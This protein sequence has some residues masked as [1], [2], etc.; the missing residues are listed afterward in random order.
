MGRYLPLDL[1]A[2]ANAGPEAGK[3]ERWTPNGPPVRFHSAERSASL[4]G[5]P[6]GR[7]RFWGVPFLLADPKENGGAAWIV[8]SADPAWA[9]P[10]SVTVSLPTPTIAGSLVFAHCADVDAPES[11]VGDLLATYTLVL[12][13]GSRPSWPIRRGF[14][15]VARRPGV[16]LG[17]AYASVSH[18]EPR[19]VRAPG[20]AAH[21]LGGAISS[22]DPQS[23]WLWGVDNPRPEAPIVAIELAAAHHDVIVVAAITLV[24]QGSNPLRRSGRT[25]IRVDLP[26]VDEEGPA[27]AA[28]DEEFTPPPEL[29][30]VAGSVSLTVD[31]GQIVRA[32]PAHETTPDAW[33]DA[34]VKGWGRPIDRGEPSAIHAE[35]YAADSAELTVRRG[36]SAW[37]VPWRDV[38]GGEA[39]STDGRV[40][41]RVMDA[42]R[43]RV[44]V[45]VVDA[46]TGQE[47]ATRV[48]FQGPSGEYLPPLGHSPEVNVNWC[49]DI[50]G[51]LRL[52]ATN[53]AYVPGRFEAELPV[54]SVYA[55]AVHGF[56]YTPVREVLTIAPGQSDLRLPIRRWVD[57]RRRGYYSGD[58][59]VHFLDPSTATLEAAAEDLNVTELLAIQQG[60]LHE[61]TVHGIGRVAPGS[62]HEHVIR[63]DSE[64][65]HHMLGHIFLLGLTEPVLPLSSGGT[66]E[67]ELGG[68]D[69]V[70]MADWC[71]RCRAQGGLVVTQFTPTPHAE[72]VADIILGKI[73]ATEVRWFDFFPAGQPGG[74]WGDTPFAFPG[75]A[76]WYRYLNCGYRVP[77][78]GGTDK[79]TNAIAIGALRTYVR[80]DEG[81]DFSYQAWNRAIKRGRTFVSCGPIIELTVEGCEPGDEIRLPRGGG[82]LNVTATARSAQRF[83]R[84]EIVRNG[85]VVAR[86]RTDADGLSASVTASLEVPES[87]WIAA[88]CY[89]R[90]KLWTSSPI[91]VG[92]HTSPV[93]VTVDGRRQSLTRDASQLLTL[94]EGGL[95]Y[96]DALAAFR[97][98]TQREHHRNV[99][100]AGR[101]ALLHHHPE[102]RPH[103][104]G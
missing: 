1:S 92:A 43:A 51:D 35:V 82:T 73:D 14:E 18:S 7:R 78:V 90:E 103:W 65:R 61:G 79:M 69:E 62:T 86:G 13:D 64:N 28:A 63:I 16:G 27:V 68:W 83:E 34:P 56:E 60:R 94:I 44:R 10:G 99:F 46:E 93:W 47:M 20:G 81:E 85:L 87:S 23:F 71:D 102:A 88:R 36:D 33:R 54:G 100:L 3:G 25:R 19:P 50:G 80:L 95:A 6:V 22:G 26:P 98:P 11:R 38:Q 57:M 53:Y 77:A 17:R 52:G 30:G 41:V 84:I 12:A 59:H 4:E 67:D 29:V 76:Q 42:Q 37:T 31:V 58:V 72:V 2:H 89:G 66:S 5:F 32:G 104:Q 45:T 49:Q 8:A 24:R 48:H 101:E 39:R 55:E 97:S 75:V 96:L 74:H 91:D 21:E 9:L 15:I 40:R 70:A